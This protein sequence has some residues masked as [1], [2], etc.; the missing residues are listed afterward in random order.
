MGIKLIL[1]F[2]VAGLVVSQRTCCSDS[3]V[4]VSGNG[5][6]SGVPDIVTLT[7]TISEAGN[8]SKQ[9][10]SAV[11]FKS[12][13]VLQILSDNDIATKDIKTTQLSIFPK[14]DWSQGVQTLRSQ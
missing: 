1:A 14:Y 7:I 6:A 8:T 11:N 13:Q 2:V 3:T 9:A 10:S 4:T 12:S 5:R